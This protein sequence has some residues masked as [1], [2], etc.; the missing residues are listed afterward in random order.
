MRFNQSERSIFQKFFGPSWGHGGASLV[1]KHFGRPHF[2]IRLAG[3]AI[4]QVLVN[5]TIALLFLLFFD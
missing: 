3:P 2:E 1:T 5:F 4:Y